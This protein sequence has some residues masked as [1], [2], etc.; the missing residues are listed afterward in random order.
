MEKNYRCISW[1]STCMRF[2]LKHFM[3][4]LVPPE[5]RC[6]LYCRV[7]A[8]RAYYRLADKVIDGTPCGPENTYD[9]CVDGT[10]HRTGCD[11]V[12]DSKTEL[13]EW[14]LTSYLVN[15]FNKIGI[16]VSIYFKML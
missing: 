15:C 2:Y 8:S 13:G 11:H 10:C 3:L 9:I 4:C 14:K 7:V 12:L 6:K 1:C 16:V 5:D